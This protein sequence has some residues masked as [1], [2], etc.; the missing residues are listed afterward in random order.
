M[1][2]RRFIFGVLVLC[3]TSGS[4]RAQVEVSLPLDGYFRAGQ[5]MPVHLRAGPNAPLREVTIDGD[6]MVPTVVSAGGGE[7]VVPVLVISASAREV[8]VARTGDAKPTRLPLRELPADRQMIALIRGAGD[9]LARF[10]PPAPTVVRIELDRAL[11]RDAPPIAMEL[12]QAILLDDPSLIK[13]PGAWLASGVQLLLVGRAPPDKVWPWVQMQGLSRLRVDPLGPRTALLGDE[14]Y[15]PAQG[16]SPGRSPSLRRQVLL[17]G[18]LFAIIAIACA[19]LPRR[20]VAMGM[21]GLVTVAAVVA[22]YAWQRAQSPLNVLAG[23]IAVD[24]QPVAQWDQWTYFT[25]RTATTASAPF[26]EADRP[27]LIDGAHADRARLRLY[28]SDNSSGRYFE[29]LLGAEER[30]GFL[31]RY[32][33]DAMPNLTPEPAHNPFAQ[34]ARSFYANEGYTVLG[35]ETWHDGPVVLIVRKP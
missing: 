8:V 21:L 30:L 33:K 34:L 19:L 24:H 4:S 13:D 5:Y 12:L 2:V 14:A 7:V 35:E 16:W 10:I 31:S 22:I 23:Q 11:V 28:W 6:G 9:E 1:N 18:V 20:A 17:A 29:F 3:A 26:I 15:L 25:S 27:I 32:A